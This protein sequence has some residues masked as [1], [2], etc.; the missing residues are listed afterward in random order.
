[1]RKQ[2]TLNN[3]KFIWE[4]KIKEAGATFAIIPR[5]FYFPFFYFVK[6]LLSVP[7]QKPSVYFYKLLICGSQLGVDVLS[8]EKIYW[9]A[10]KRSAIHYR[11]YLIFPIWNGKMMTS[12]KIDK[13][14]EPISKELNTIW[15]G[16]YFD[17]NLNSA[18]SI[19]SGAMRKFWIGF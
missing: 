4:I 6:S 10:I 13:I 18:I 11:G 7:R 9:S 2:I 1:M 8:T 12:N 5:Y 3:V 17:I 19:K 14:K 16:L 15:E